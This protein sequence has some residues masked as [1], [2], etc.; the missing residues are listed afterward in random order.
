VNQAEEFG[1]ERR[2]E[3]EERGVLLD[4]GVLLGECDERRA[5]VEARLGVRRLKRY[6]LAQ[7][8]DRLPVLARLDQ[9]DAEVVVPFGEARPQAR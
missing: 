9:R 3:C 7:R 8:R 2:V 4:G 5:E 1:G 6:G